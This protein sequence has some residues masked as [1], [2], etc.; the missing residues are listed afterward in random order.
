MVYCVVCYLMFAFGLWR[1]ICCFVAGC[2]GFGFGLLVGVLFIGCFVRFAGW[3]Y[4][5]CCVFDCGC[6]LELGDLSAAW[7]FYSCL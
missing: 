6:Y 1:V 4:I 3:R 5:A 7:V 2:G